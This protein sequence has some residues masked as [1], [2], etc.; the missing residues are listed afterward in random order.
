MVANPADAA[1]G[2][3]HRSRSFQQRIGA[4]ARRRRSRSRSKD[5]EE[6]VGKQHAP[7]R[8]KSGSAIPYAA[9]PS[10]TM[11][12]GTSP[13]SGPSRQ[14]PSSSQ[15]PQ[16]HQHQHQDH[17]FSHSAGFSSESSMSADETL[18]VTGI[19]IRTDSS[20][21]KPNVMKMQPGP[22]SYL[23]SSSDDDDDKLIPVKRKSGRGGMALLRKTFSGDGLKRI[24][25]GR[26]D[27]DG[28][29][30]NDAKLADAAVMPAVLASSSTD[31]ISNKDGSAS[32]GVNPENM[33]DLYEHDIDEAIKEL[34]FLEETSRLPRER[35][36]PKIRWNDITLEE[37]LGYGGFSQVNR[38]LV[39]SP[40]LQGKDGNNN[41]N[42]HSNKK[43]STTSSTT[44]NEGRRYA[45]KCLDDRL[46]QSKDRKKVIEAALDVAVEGDILAR[47]SHPNI[48]QLHGV[49]TTNLITVRFTHKGMRDYFLL[50]DLLQETLLDRLQVWRRKIF[51]KSL[52]KRPLSKKKMLERIEVAAVGVARGMAY[53]HEKKVVLRD[54][55]RVNAS[56]VTRL[57]PF[58]LLLYFEIPV[59]PNYRNLKTSALIAMGRQ[60]CLIL[61]SQERPI[62]SDQMKLLEGKKS[63]GAISC[64]LVSS[65][66]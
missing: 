46:L 19:D 39:K 63:R 41:S 5:E 25:R 23:I 56:R 35:E 62:M 20:P 29:S 2:F 65:W 17:P 16:Q 53:L 22:S 51:L 26:S 58:F 38:A 3:S 40:L 43:K 45:L 14:A 11:N 60:S 21:P 48:I 49:S 44:E 31:V 6:D 61:V 7:P 57:N 54:L 24:R 9:A 28:E 64:V 37:V 13:N 32:S 30:D 50:L 1:A 10:S 8:S 55:V 34:R 36:I 12:T 66:F 33:D 47:L 42:N 18:M 4:I 52:V 59:S 15:R 27:G